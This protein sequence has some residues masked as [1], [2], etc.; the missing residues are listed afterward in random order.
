MLTLEA[1]DKN[2][3]EFLLRALKNCYEDVEGFEAIF[4]QTCEEQR[5]L[6]LYGR[7]IQHRLKADKALRDESQRTDGE[8]D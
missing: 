5:L 2:V 7:E 8:P 3:T 1:K 6:E 4:N